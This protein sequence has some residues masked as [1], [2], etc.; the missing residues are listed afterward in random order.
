MA[1]E[2]AIQLKGGGGGS[3][4]GEVRNILL[5]IGAALDMRGE[6]KNWAT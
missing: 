2:G 4:S 1:Q 5:Y 3:H 6:S